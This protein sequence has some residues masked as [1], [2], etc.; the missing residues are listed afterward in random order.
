MLLVCAHAHCFSLDDAVKVS[1]NPLCQDGSQFTVSYFQ[2]T[3]QSLISYFGV[4]I[5]GFVFSHHGPVLVVSF[6]SQCTCFTVGKKKSNANPHYYYYFYYYYLAK[7]DRSI[8][9]F[10]LVDQSRLKV[11]VI[12]SICTQHLISPSQLPERYLVS[13]FAN[14][15]LKQT[16]NRTIICA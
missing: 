4:K 9:A 16:S 11:P 2:E 1:I 12:V 3:R 13:T 14:V 6:L 15:Q 10:Q 5:F 8:G 7:Y